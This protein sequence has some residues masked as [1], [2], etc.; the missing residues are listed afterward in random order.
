MM[1]E[2]GISRTV[3]IAQRTKQNLAFFDK[4]KQNGATVFEFTQLL[5]SMLG[6]LIIVS[7]DYFVRQVVVLTPEEDQELMHVRVRSKPPLS[8]CRI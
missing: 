4:E 2:P 7:E 8:T 1:I 6:M 5:N 3:E